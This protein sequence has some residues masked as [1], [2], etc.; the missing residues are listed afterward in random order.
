MAGHGAS[1]SGWFGWFSW[2]LEAFLV[3]SHGTNHEAR[4]RGWYWGE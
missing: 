2:E 1:P 3:A 4:P